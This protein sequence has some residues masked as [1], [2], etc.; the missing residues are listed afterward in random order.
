L[1]RNRRF[2]EMLGLGKT[3][4]EAEQALDGVVEGVF[5]VK[6]ALALGQKLD[7]EL[8][9]IEQVHKIVHDGADP[10]SAV[11]ALMRRDFRE[12]LL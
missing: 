10:R 1:S 5:T 7:V 12:E 4:A 9:I 8:P 11:A 3:R 6:A 2:G